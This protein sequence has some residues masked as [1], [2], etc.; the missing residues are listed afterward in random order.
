MPFPR[1]HFRWLS[2]LTVSLLVLAGCETDEIRTYTVPKPP[3][4]RLL[5]AIVEN[6]PDQWFFKLVGPSDTVDQ[7]SKAFLEFIE[8]V[9]F[10]NKPEH[11]IEW[12]VPPGWENEPGK[13]LRY[14]TL[15][16]V[17]KGKLPEVSIFKF[18]PISPLLENVNR[19]R[20]NDLGLPPLAEEEL[21]PIT[22]RFRVGDRTVA[23]V[24]M[25]GPGGKK[26][27]GPPMMAN[28]PSVEPKKP[29]SLPITYTV[30]EGWTETGPRS[31][32]IVVLTSFQIRE[33]GG[34][35]QVDVTPLGPMTGDL[36]ANVNRWRSQV[37]LQP[38]GQAELQ[39]DPPRDVKVDGSAGTYFDLAGPAGAG[40]KRMLV[41]MFKRGQR[42]W[43]LKMIG[44]ADVV[45]KNKGKF[46]SFVQSVKFT[47]ASDE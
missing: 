3:K 14:A 33:G 29:R 18:K 15:F 47:G 16:P 45:A 24:D 19:W 39:K 4:V 12:K 10:P 30:P 5:A 7:H 11:P 2:V 44:D 46:E 8:S 25:I 42:T 1:K 23:W 28:P 27:M 21:P 6:S 40:A 34:S 43:Y 35:A 13:D 32:M 9:R 17:G 20:R 38:I 31:G 22:K 26:G 37:A 36:L 41:V